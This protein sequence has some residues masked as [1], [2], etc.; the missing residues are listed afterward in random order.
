MDD[1]NWN[2]SGNWWR[3]G[4][5]MT[6]QDVDKQDGQNVARRD[7]DYNIFLIYNYNFIQKN[8]NLRQQ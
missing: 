3:C 6:E 5:A 8:Y 7:M 1:C 2:I 4:M